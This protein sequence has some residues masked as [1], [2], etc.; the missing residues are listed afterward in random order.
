VRGSAPACNGRTN[1][2]SS[3]ACLR[4]TAVP[5]AASMRRSRLGGAARCGVGVLSVFRYLAAHYKVLLRLSIHPMRSIPLSTLRHSCRIPFGLRTS[6][7]RLLYA[8]GSFLLPVLAGG[9]AEDEGERSSNA[10]ARGCCLR[11]RNACTVSH[12]GG[13]GPHSDVPTMVSPK[14]VT[15]SMTLSRGTKL[16]LPCSLCLVPSSSFSSSLGRS[17]HLAYMYLL[18]SPFLLQWLLLPSG[19]LPA[20]PSPG[21][22]TLPL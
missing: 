22:H 6:R 15:T 2:A 1:A 21:R 8:H 5:L 4:S 14:Q 9:F 17:S 20:L 7:G 13:A 10:R 12:S 18:L 11:A 3:G 16:L 19:L